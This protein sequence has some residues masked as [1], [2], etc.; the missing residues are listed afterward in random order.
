MLSALTNR[1]SVLDQ[2]RSRFLA[3]VRAASESQQRFRPTAESW[4]LLEVTEHCV[5]AEE[6]SLQGMLNGPPPGTTVTP[7][8]HVRMGMVRLVMKSDIRVKVPV[9]RVMPL[10]HS[11]LPEL[12]ARWG[13]SRRGLETFL[14]Q[15]TAADAGAA[16]FRHPIGG[17]VTAS[18][19][20]AFLAGHIGHHARQLVRIQR[21]TGFP[22][23]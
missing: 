3:T 16:R 22:S 17:W 9:A 1:L 6:K 21:A 7:I 4:S 11:S 13:E 10:G 14:E 2:A 18:A 5:L 23:S 8:A 15:L 20:V 19:G 12:E